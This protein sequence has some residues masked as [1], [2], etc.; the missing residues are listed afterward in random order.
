[1]NN[2]PNL[3]QWR[4][5]DVICAKRL[6]EM[7]C[8]INGFGNT[9]NTLTSLHTSLT[10]NGLNTY[11]TFKRQL[12]RMH[13]EN[14]AAKV[15][16]TFVASP[17]TESVTTGVYARNNSAISYNNNPCFVESECFK[18]ITC[19]GEKKYIYQKITTDRTGVPTCI[20]IVAFC[21][22]AKPTSTLW[23]Y[24]ATDD[25]SGNGTI[26]NPVS[27]IVRDCRVSCKNNIISHKYTAIK[28][29]NFFIHPIPQ[30]AE[31]S[32]TQ[33]VNSL[34]GNTLPIKT[35]NGIDGT[36]V[37]AETN[38]VNIGSGVT[39]SKC[40]FTTTT[41]MP[42]CVCVNWTQDFGFKIRPN[43]CKNPYKFIITPFGAPGGGG[44]TY[45]AGDGIDITNNCISALK[46]HSDTCK[47]GSV[48]NITQSSQITEP[49]I[50]N[51]H[52]VIP[53]TPAVSH[54]V[55]H[56][57]SPLPVDGSCG[58]VLSAYMPM[59]YQVSKS[60]DTMVSFKQL[61]RFNGS[62]LEVSWQRAIMPNGTWCAYGMCNYYSV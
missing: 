55:C 38:H 39:F 14:G 57:T 24:A 30:N 20:D 13:N 45:Y 15:V 34:D 8:R 17:S 23:N 9:D 7:V 54:S 5:G 46:A 43:Q 58:W 27:K 12:C 6:N 50:D 49:Y 60:S 41:H 11:G 47:L 52:I 32:Y 4:R 56:I 19:I 59:V 22:A 3:C 37:E 36:T 10:G 35:L 33:L 31:S 40:A 2:I 62:N 29:N 53:Q 48:Y 25:S 1:M 61:M 51:G 26:Y 28:S 16:D 42:S 21:C 44:T 18:F